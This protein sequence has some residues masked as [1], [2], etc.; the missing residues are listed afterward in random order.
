MKKTLV[1]LRCETNSLSNRVQVA[2]YQFLKKLFDG[3]KQSREQMEKI[4]EA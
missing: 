2:F 4:A 3:K 1:D